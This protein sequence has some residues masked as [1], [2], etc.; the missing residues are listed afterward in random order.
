MARDD[1]SVEDAIRANRWLLDA[2]LEQFPDGA[3]N[4]FDRA[5]LNAVRKWRYNPKVQDGQPVERPG[6]KVRLDFQ[7]EH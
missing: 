4:V 7:M 2:L 3:V 6:V 5:A 1:R